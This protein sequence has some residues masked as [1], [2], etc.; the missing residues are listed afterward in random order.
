[1]NFATSGRPRTLC[2]MDVEP[3][4]QVRDLYNYWRAQRELHY[5]TY[6]VTFNYTLEMMEQTSR[7][8]TANFLRDA[9]AKGC[10]PFLL[11]ECLMNAKPKPQPQQKE[12]GSE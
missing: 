5:L 11:T 1:M 7:D 10:P 6:T 8:M 2:L 3:P 4:R 12:D 9:L